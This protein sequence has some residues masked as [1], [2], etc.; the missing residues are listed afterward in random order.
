MSNKHKK[1]KKRKEDSPDKRNF[2]GGTPKEP[3]RKKTLGGK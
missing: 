1:D 3:E 2:I